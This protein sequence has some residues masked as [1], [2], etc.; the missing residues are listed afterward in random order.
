LSATWTEDVV[1]LTGARGGSAGRGVPTAGDVPGSPERDAA[2]P[3]CGNGEA[4]AEARSAQR[5]PQR[6]PEPRRGLPARAALPLALAGGLALTAAFPPFGIWPLAIVAPAALV[7]ALWQRGTGGSLV[8]GLIFGLGFFV[9]LLSWLVNVAWYAWAALAVAESIVFALLC[10][11]HRVMLRLPAWPVAV[12]AWWVA[13]EAVRSRWPYA[14]PWG[15]LAMSQASAP[16]ARWAAAGGPTLL[17]FLLALA[18]TLLAWTVIG[19]GAL[20]R[21]DARQAWQLPAL[22][23]ATGRAAACAAAIVVLLAGALLPFSRAGSAAAASAEIMAVQGN[24]P[25]ARNLPSLWRKARVTLN[26]AIA[27]EQAAAQVRAGSRAQPALVIWPENSTDIDPGL[28]PATY[29]T[30]AGAV[31]A[32]HAPVLVGA[33]LQN[34]LRNTGQLWLP[35][36]GPTEIYVKRQLVPFGEYIPFRGF[37]ETFSSLP[38]LQP[39][40]Y[41]AGRRAVVFHIGKIRLGDVICYEV[42][43]DGLV[44]SEV[45]G[46]ANLLTEQTNDADFEIDGQTGETLQQLAMARLRAIEYDRSIVVAGTTGVS[47]II[48][49]DGAFLA[50]SRMWQRS[51]LEARVP[52]R[53]DA[54]PADWLGGW[55]EA[56]FVALAVASFLLAGAGAIRDRTGRGRATVSRDSRTTPVNRT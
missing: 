40:N 16:T 51:V 26:H 12:A 27:T 50:R 41:T 13:A 33:V 55:P 39:V 21:G 2:G 53:T 56:L 42:G 8:A 38:R 31:R 29:A 19:E 10:L 46:G 11:A 48:A 3:V 14:F 17:S 18:G 45:R 28:D 23:Q 4:A 49:P 15:R 54:T 9:P 34:P 20:G 7:L 24:V 6:A 47:A 25:H 43:F 30:I 44:A 5:G 35:G 32:I 36:R 52:L 1:R 37:I 22:R